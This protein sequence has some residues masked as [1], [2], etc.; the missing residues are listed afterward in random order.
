MNHSITNHA[1]ATSQARFLEL[2]Y[3]RW[4]QQIPSS[5]AH[6]Y[7]NESDTLGASATAGLHASTALASVAVATVPTR[8]WRDDPNHVAGADTGSSNAAATG[9]TGL[10][11][12]P[13]LPLHRR[14]VEWARCS[15]IVGRDWVTAILTTITPAD[16]TALAKV[17]GFSACVNLP[18]PGYNWLSHFRPKTTACDCAAIIDRHG[19]WFS[20]PIHSTA[21]VCHE[22]AARSTKLRNSLPTRFAHD[23][24]LSGDA[25][26]ILPAKSLCCTAQHPVEAFLAS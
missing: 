5:P 23:A 20:P 17:L 3:I 22:S 2:Q 24:A 16:L 9:A 11:F 4:R 15:C 13:A 19:R 6:V 12:L 25:L 18:V 21:F 8:S 14:E 10:V 1:S 26:E 7:A